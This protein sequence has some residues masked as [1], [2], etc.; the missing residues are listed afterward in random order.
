MRVRRHTRNA[1]LELR[2][3]DRS[4]VKIKNISRL[5]GLWFHHNPRPDSR[6]HR[7]PSII[8]FN[9]HEVVLRK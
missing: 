2:F 4:P 5:N 3:D 8:F 1:E 9:V 6:D 7:Q